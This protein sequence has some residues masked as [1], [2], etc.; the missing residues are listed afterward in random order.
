MIITTAFRLAKNEKRM[1]AIHLALREIHITAVGPLM[2]AAGARA[3]MTVS[4]RVAAIR[5]PVDARA[6][7]SSPRITAGLRRNLSNTQAGSAAQ[8]DPQKCR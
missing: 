1:I 6:Q 8:P 2:T 3:T 7:E 5:V 4:R